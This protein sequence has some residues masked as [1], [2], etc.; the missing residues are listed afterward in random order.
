[1]NSNTIDVVLFI[2]QL[3]DKFTVLLFSHG[4]KDEKPVDLVLSCVDN[5]EAR[6]AINT[7]SEHFAIFVPYQIS[8]HIEVLNFSKFILGFKV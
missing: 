3:T 6:M 7:V 4:G 5:F 8:R 1:M 2:Y